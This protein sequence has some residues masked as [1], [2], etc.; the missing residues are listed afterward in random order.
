[1]SA[2]AKPSAPAKAPPDWTRAARAGLAE[3]SP[4]D[5]QRLLMDLTAMPVHSRAPSLCEPENLL[6]RAQAQLLAP[7]GFP[8]GIPPGAI[9]PRLAA[10]AEAGA[11]LHKGKS[12]H[13]AVH[14]K[15]IEMARALLDMPHGPRPSQA[16][17]A[18]ASALHRAAYAGPD[19]L[20]DLLAERSDPADWDRLDKDN[21][22]PLEKALMS[23]RLGRA[24]KAASRAT[25]SLE[26]DANGDTLFH[27]FARFLSS[28]PEA[29][30]PKWI[31][32][33]C[34]LLAKSATAHFGVLNARGQTPETLLSECG[35]ARSMVDRAIL[36][37]ES[38]GAPAEAEAPRPRS[39][40]RL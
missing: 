20:F 1:M 22:T 12:L 32:L 24:A 19:A 40:A 17:G 8:N 38:P 2:K 26:L 5:A 23:R 21:R 10:L 4:Q 37:L 18:G 7:A 16:S 34:G 6:W 33:F 31:P 3:C 13:R 39:R 36:L 35:L 27:R 11:D 28:L 29:E 25:A 14:R 30:Q 9:G 15:D